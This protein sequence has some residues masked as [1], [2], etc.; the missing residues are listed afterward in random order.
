MWRGSKGR[1][2]RRDKRSRKSGRE[3][4]RRTKI[5]RDEK[6]TGEVKCREEKEGLER[7]T[8]GAKE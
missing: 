4:I 5:R 1:T 2:G 6:V 3:P 8:G 7:L